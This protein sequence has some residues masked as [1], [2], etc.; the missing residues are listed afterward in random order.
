MFLLYLDH[1]C[2]EL[3]QVGL[4]DVYFYGRKRR[5]GRYNMADSDIFDL[6]KLLNPDTQYCNV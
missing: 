2:F 6:F 5:E 4:G 3:Y 1:S